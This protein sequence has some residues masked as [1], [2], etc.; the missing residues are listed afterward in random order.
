M[1]GAKSYITQRTTVAASLGAAGGVIGSIV[2]GTWVVASTFATTQTAIAN[3]QSTA[4]QAAQTAKAV[5]LEAD[6]RYDLLLDEIR[7]LQADI[8]TLLQRK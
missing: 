3:A 8:K 6:K 4:D 5:K 1:T 2:I 7:V